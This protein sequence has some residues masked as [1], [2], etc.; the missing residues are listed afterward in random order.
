MH[1]ITSPYT[2]SL[3]ALSLTKCNPFL[4]GDRFA[5]SHFAPLPFKSRYLSH[6]SSEWTEIWHDDSLDAIDRA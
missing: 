5:R 1:R 3:N 2:L 6:F 4:A